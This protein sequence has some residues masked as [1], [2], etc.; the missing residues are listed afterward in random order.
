[1]HRRLATFVP[2]LLAACSLQAPTEIAGDRSDMIP[3]GGGRQAFALGYACT[4]IDNNGSASEAGRTFTLE[5]GRGATIKPEESGPCT[6]TEQDADEPRH[7]RSFAFGGETCA[8]D[9][10]DA[11]IELAAFEAADDTIAIVTANEDRDYYHCVG[12]GGGK[13]DAGPG[14][15]DARVR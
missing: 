5:L 7:F 13:P 15:A 6:G 1:M 11:A 2:L 8:A 14:D 3:D 9:G 12:G 10:F 4:R